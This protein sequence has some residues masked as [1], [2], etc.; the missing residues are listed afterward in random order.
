[1][2]TA[3]DKTACYTG[4][5]TAT[6]QH[7]DAGWAGPRVHHLPARAYGCVD[8]PPQLMSRRKAVGRAFM[9]CFGLARSTH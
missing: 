3:S 4:R 7:G 8:A 6:W 2:T 1:M 9:G 5:H